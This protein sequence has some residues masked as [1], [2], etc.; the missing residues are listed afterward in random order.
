MTFTWA[1]RDDT[2]DEL[3][4][5]RH[6][7]EVANHLFEQLPPSVQR[8]I[9]AGASRC[10]LTK[11]AGPLATLS[12]ETRTRLAAI[13]TD[14]TGQVSQPAAAAPNLRLVDPEGG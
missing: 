13:L 12:T 8:E 10:E 6:V 9:D 5:W 14:I 7:L 11:M 1:N 2:E 4:L 3:A